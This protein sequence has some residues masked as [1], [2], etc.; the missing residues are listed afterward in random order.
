MAWNPSPEVAAARDF[1]NKFGCRRVI[2]LC[3]QE[4]GRFGYVSY[5]KTRKLCDGTKRIADAL[6]G[7]FE[8][9]LIAENDREPKGGA[10]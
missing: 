7:E 5:G 10:K 4:D 6:L 8:Y 3:E 2:V 9:E 1:A